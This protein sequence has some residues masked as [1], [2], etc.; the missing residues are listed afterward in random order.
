MKQI[1]GHVGKIRH[2]NRVVGQWVKRHLER[3]LE[4]HLA[5]QEWERMCGR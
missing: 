4:R 5:V 2:L 1:C 3:R